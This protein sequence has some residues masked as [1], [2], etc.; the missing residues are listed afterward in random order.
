MKTFKNTP[1]SKP[2]ELIEN[3]YD[4]MFQSLVAVSLNFADL[5]I[6]L[7][8]R[9]TSC[10]SPGNCMILSVNELV[11]NIFF[12][13]KGMVVAFHVDHTGAKV[14]YALFVEGEMAILPGIL[15]QDKPSLFYLMACPE[16]H[17]IE[18]QTTDLAQVQAAFPN[19]ESLIEK[20]INH[21]AYKPLERELLKQF[22]AEERITEF[23]KC[24]FI[25]LP[26]GRKNIIDRD[27]I[28]SY[29]GITKQSL[30][31]LLGEIRKKVAEAE[32]RTGIVGGI[33]WTK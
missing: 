6:D 29:L 14:T 27:V 15:E 25:V 26:Y 32:K 28:A 7:K 18:I 21:Q 20:M 22:T 30:S 33:K 11:K 13:S 8:P 1:L 4:K 9:L 3:H 5:L 31:R 12:V 10:Y 2:V 24:F 19:T 23:F 17:L 16:T